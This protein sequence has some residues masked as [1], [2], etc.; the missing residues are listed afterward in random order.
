MKILIEKH[1]EFNTENHIAFVDFKKAFDRVNRKELLRILASDQVSQQT[2]Q[3]IYNLYKT[4]LISVKIEDKLSEWREINTGVRHG[5]GLLPVLFIIYM[6]AIIKEFRQKR[7]GYIAINRTLQLDA[8]IFADDLV[9]L[10][11]SED[12]LQH[13]L[14]NFK[15]VAWNTPWKYPQR[16]LK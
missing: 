2:I 12:D 5:C 16:R 15:L 13:S 7:H 4:N 10:A 11:A 8:M 9:V 1:R 6:N 3:N 14:Y